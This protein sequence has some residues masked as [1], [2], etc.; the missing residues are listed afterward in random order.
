M[1]SKVD[2]AVVS[3]MSGFNCAQ[4]VF[5]TYAE[6]FGM[7]KT[8]ALKIST[9]FGA[10]MGRLQN[11]C[12]ALTGAFMLIGCKHGRIQK[13]DAATTERA[14]TLVTEFSHQFSTRYGNSSCKELLEC[15]LKTTEGQ[16]YFRENNLKEQKCA[17]Y[18]RDAATMVEELL[19]QEKRT[20]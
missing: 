2:S 18:V 10:G 12:G 7:N 17:C 13:D 20:T 14:Y 8:D 5:S 1:D 3:F 6:E 9:G 16:K 11:V 19:I 4:A 15:D